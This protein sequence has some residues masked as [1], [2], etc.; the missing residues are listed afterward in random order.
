[1][2][3]KIDIFSGFLGAG[4][5]TLIRKLINEAYRNEKI[6]LIENEFGEISIDSDF[7]A[8]AGVKIKEMS[9]GCICCSLVGD[10]TQSL[11]LVL[12]Q[13]QPERIIIEP[14]GVGKLSDVIKAVSKVVSDDVVL[15]SY[16]T[17]VDANKM[18][19]YSKNFGEFYNDQIKSANCIIISRSQQ[20]SQQKLADICDLIKEVNPT[21]TII[22]TQWDK[23]DG[24]TIVDTMEH[25]ESVQSDINELTEQLNCQHHHHHDENEECCCHHH[26]DENEECCCHHDHDD[27]E[28]CCDHDEHDHHHHHAEEVFSSWGN[29]TSRIFSKQQIESIL[30]KLSDEKQYGLVLRAKGILQCEDDKWIYFDYVPNEIDIREGNP[31]AMSRYCVI[32]SKINEE[33]LE[34]LFEE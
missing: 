20:V 7:L 23:L 8:D 22:T 4:K 32:G 17:V 15:N 21:A 11:K 33:A 30:E 14:S 16:T 2:K 12:D 9:Q 19:M 1:M 26:H 3:T 29:Q 28:C 31:I 25:K 13:Y 34:R 24:K 5:T 10:F 27:N 18:L 6:V